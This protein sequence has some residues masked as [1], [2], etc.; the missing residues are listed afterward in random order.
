MTPLYEKT[1]E[2]KRDVSQLRPEQ[3][4]A[5]P[6][7]QS[8]YLRTTAL[9]K[10]NAESLGEEVCFEEL[11]PESLLTRDRTAAELTAHG[12]PVAAKTLAT[13]ASRGGG[14]PFRKF[15]P[16][17]I[18]S[19]ADALEWAQA[20]LS[21]PRYSTSERDACVRRSAPAGKRGGGPGSGRHGR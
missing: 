20:R 2:R 21:A 13:L 7:R 18:Y 3:V 14:P 1:T 11:T 19:W 16:R 10:S 15:G 5:Q 4:R 17:A 8:L 6:R 12:F 9:T